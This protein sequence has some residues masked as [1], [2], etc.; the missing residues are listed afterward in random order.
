VA[1]NTTADATA[2]GLDSNGLLEVSVAGAAIYGIA[3]LLCSFAA[4]WVAGRERI[5]FE[6]RK[7]AYSVALFM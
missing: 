1:E 3:V 5:R 7:F 6:P 4:F 2:I